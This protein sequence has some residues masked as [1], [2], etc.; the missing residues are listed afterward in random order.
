VKGGGSQGLEA[1]GWYPIFQNQTGWV[2][3]VLIGGFYSI[4]QE[5]LDR[6]QEIK[7]DQ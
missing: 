3:Y 5:S 7:M 1:R 6:L 4:C 2:C